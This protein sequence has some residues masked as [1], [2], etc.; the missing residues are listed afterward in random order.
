MNNKIESRE[1]RELEPI[2]GTHGVSAIFPKFQDIIDYEEKRIIL[3]Q[4]YPRFVTHP[5]IKNI[6]QEYKHLFNCLD[7]FAFHNY[8]VAV[9]IV[10]DY[11]YRNYERIFSNKGFSKDIYSL[12]EN[13]FHL[14][15]STPIKD[16][17]VLFLDIKSI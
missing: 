3:Q 6:E 17:E 16:A 13:K 11:F 15:K 14:N 10:V 1:I 7:V 12:L 2:G 5:F 8:K 9:F 4:G